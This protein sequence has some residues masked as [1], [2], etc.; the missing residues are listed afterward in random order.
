MSLRS[1]DEIY[2][3]QFQSELLPLHFSSSLALQLSDGRASCRRA[4]HG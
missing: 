1:V 2:L 4:Q 3:G